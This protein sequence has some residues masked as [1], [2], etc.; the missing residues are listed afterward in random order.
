MASSALPPLTAEDQAL[1]DRLATR[2]VELHMEVPAILALETSKPMTV[3]ASQA[4]IFFEPMIQSLFRFT[5]YR[6]FTALV[7]RRDVM[8]SLIQ[9]IEAEGERMRAQRA[10]ARRAAGGRRP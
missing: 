3:I 7:E 8:E 10:Q 9:R 5:D 6:R 1:L 2:V 4:L